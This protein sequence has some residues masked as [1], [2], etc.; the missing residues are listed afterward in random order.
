VAEDYGVGTL[1]EGMDNYE[2]GQLLEGRV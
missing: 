1:L 2:V